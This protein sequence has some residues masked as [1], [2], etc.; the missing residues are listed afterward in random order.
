MLKENRNTHQYNRNQYK[1]ILVTEQ[2]T[3]MSPHLRSTK[4]INITHC[5]IH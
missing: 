1:H 5:R 3:I 2:K 4:L